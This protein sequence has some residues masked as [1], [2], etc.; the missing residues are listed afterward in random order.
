[1]TFIRRV[2]FFSALL[3]TSDIGRADN[4]PQWR[5]PTY[6]GICAETG[7]PATLS[8]DNLIWKLKMPGQGG[9]TPAV[10]GDRIFLTSEDA[11]KNVVMLCVST[12]GKELWRRTLGPG[13]GSYMRGEGNDASASPSTDGKYVYYFTGKGDLGC[14]DF[15]GNS[16][17][18]LSAQE[19]YGKFKMQWG[20]HTSPLLFRDRL[21]LQLINSNGAWVIALDKMTG[22]E[23]WKVDRP[24]EAK[25]ECKESYA[26]VVPWVNGSEAY[27]I[28]HGADYTIAHRL[29]DGSEIWRLGD[30]N[31]ITPNGKY[32]N[33]LRLVASPVA[34]ATLI[35][36]PT[37]K[38][39]PVIG[40][41]PDAHGKIT[42]GSA[43]EAWRLPKDTPDVPSPLVHGGYVYL[44]GEGGTLTCLDAATG[45]EIYSDVAHKSLHRA[46]PVYADGKIYL[47]GREGNITVVKAGPKSEILAS[48]HLKDKLYASPAFS[49]HR[50]FIRGFEYLYAFGTPVK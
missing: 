3:S 44:C 1:M 43:Q 19:R 47:T 14:F 21:Y 13:G 40:V 24:S 29:D 20:T 16:I 46:S 4:W 37:A 32:N 38:R 5:G 7:F 12:D 2:I 23:I 39:G 8:E 15:Q 36:V 48:N 11:D 28:S 49:D 9:S 17:W 33:T 6:D 35:V 34:V 42:R 45:K 18:K 10:W 41:N 27:I 26:S 50:I 25:M 31:P 22:K 30:L